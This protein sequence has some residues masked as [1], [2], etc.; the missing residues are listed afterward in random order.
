MNSKC[1]GHEE[2]LW[3]VGC[4][5]EACVAGTEEAKKKVGGDQR[6]RGGSVCGASYAILDFGIC[7]EWDGEP[8]EGFDWGRG[9]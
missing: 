9:V 8:L 4:G 5:R 6:G 3:P 2:G 7:S 1:N